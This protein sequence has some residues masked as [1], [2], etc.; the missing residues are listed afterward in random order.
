MTSDIRAAA[1]HLL[2]LRTAQE[3]FGGYV[4]LHYPDWDI[5]DFHHDLVHKL[6]LFERDQLGVDNVLVTMPPRHSKSTYSTVLEATTDTVASTLI[7]SAAL[8]AQALARS[9]GK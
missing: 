6:D 5:P 2:A 4:K 1:R 8:M 9:T 3:S 7:T